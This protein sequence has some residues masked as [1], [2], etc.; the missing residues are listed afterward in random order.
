MGL[1]FRSYTGN[2]TAPDDADCGSSCA[3]A[4]IEATVTAEAA[5]GGAGGSAR[6]AAAAARADDGVFVR[7]WGGGGARRD[8][9]AMGWF[10]AA[11]DLV[12]LA[13]GL[14]ANVYA[15]ARTRRAKERLEAGAGRKDGESNTVAF[16]G[17][18]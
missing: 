4:D 18:V 7:C 16:I 15:T 3:D 8:D 5:G 6:G 10:D 14:S 2:S 9:M 13:T 1:P 17:S 11:L 12:P